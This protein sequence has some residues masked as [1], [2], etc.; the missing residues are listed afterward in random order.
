M[1]FDFDLHYIIL[2]SPLKIIFKDFNYDYD[3]T[4]KCYIK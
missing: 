3:N 1:I 2:E 4:V